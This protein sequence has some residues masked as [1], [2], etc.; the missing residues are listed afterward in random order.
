M[1]IIGC[2]PEAGFIAAGVM[3]DVGACQRM[4]QTQERFFHQLHLKVFFPKAQRRWLSVVRENQFVF[5][6]MGV[7][8]IGRKC[9]Q[10]VD[11]L[12]KPDTEVVIFLI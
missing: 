2:V 3:C 12:R 6:T 7:K 5:H 11:L 10:R 1:K 9:S 8:V 4:L